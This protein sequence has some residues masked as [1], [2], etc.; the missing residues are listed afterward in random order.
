M[1]QS[2]YCHLRPQRNIVLRPVLESDQPFDKRA[3]I[4]GDCSKVDT[5]VASN[6]NF[7]YSAFTTHTDITNSQEVTFKTLYPYRRRFFIQNPF[8]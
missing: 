6:T 4:D 5:A 2:P 1:R 8:S 3:V 7:S